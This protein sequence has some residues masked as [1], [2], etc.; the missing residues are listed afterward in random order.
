MVVKQFDV[1]AK[2][3]ANRGAENI[4][5]LNQGIN[6]TNGYQNIF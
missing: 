4:F 1:E 2:N 5:V 6:T 3:M